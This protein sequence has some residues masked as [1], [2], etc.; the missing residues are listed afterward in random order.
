MTNRIKNTLIAGLLTVS[1]TAPMVAEAGGPRS[2]AEK[3][4]NEKKNEWRNLAIASGALG[5]LGILGKD[6]TLTTLG[7]VGALYSAY[8]YE[9]DRKSESKL[10]S[11]RAAMYSRTSFVLNGKRY[12]RK[13]VWKNGKKYYTFV[14]AR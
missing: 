11:Q 3:R 5:V 4:R 12:Q 6:G 1:L 2:Q 9:Q 7:T 13:T 8:R 14:R 10:A